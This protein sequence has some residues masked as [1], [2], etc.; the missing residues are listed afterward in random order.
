MAADL[1]CVANA[2]GI[3]LPERYCEFVKR[4]AESPRVAA[5]LGDAVSTDA[6]VVI[7]LNK[8]LWFAVP[9]AGLSEWP[10]NYFVIGEDRCGNYY[11]VDAADPEEAVLFYDHDSDEVLRIAN[12]LDDFANRR[13]QGE[14]LDKLVIHSGYQSRQDKARHNPHS[15]TLVTFSDDAPTW[16]QDWFA[17]VETFVSIASREQPESELIAALNRE[18]G[19]R[20]VCWVGKLTELDL[21][22]Y[23]SASIDMPSCE[24]ITGTAYD[25]VGSLSVSL[26]TEEEDY[27]HAQSITPEIRTPIASWRVASIGDTIRFQMMIAPGHADEI[28]CIRIH[29]RTGNRPQWVTIIDCGVHLVEVLPSS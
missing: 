24:H 23:K 28:G 22:E 11:A 18:F 27:D 5:A 15:P 1:T 2:L 10:D 21:S 20:P 25:G 19:S 17:F 7:E 12:S 3:D 6:D 4:L 9:I 14:S 29:P 16:S 26:R 8:N 13:I